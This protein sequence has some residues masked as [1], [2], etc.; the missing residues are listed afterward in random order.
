[1][2]ALYAHLKTRLWE[3]DAKGLKYYAM[4][5]KVGNSDRKA[6]KTVA[7]HSLIS[8]DAKPQSAVDEVYEVDTL[9]RAKQV[10]DEIL[11]REL[12]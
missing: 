5:R 3:I 2:K 9:E 7:T 8:V 4:A 1:M 12:I 6:L 11:K 10:F